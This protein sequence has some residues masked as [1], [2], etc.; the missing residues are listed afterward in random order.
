MVPMEEQGACEECTANCLVM[1]K[2]ERDPSPTVTTFVK[3]LIGDDYN[4]VLF[5]PPRFAE[6]VGYIMAGQTT[7]LE[8]STGVQW[9]VK[10]KK[11]DGL[12]GFENGWKE[13]ALDHRL[14][15]G[16]I[17]VFHF[18]MKSH[19]VVLMYG[20]SG[21]PEIRHQLIAMKE[22]NKSNAENSNPSNVKTNG[23]HHHNAH[24][25]S[26]K[27][28]KNLIVDCSPLDVTTTCH[29]YVNE[30]SSESER[31]QPVSKRSNH[32]ASSSR[33]V[34]PG[35]HKTGQ[36]SQLLIKNANHDPETS[37]LN[38]EMG[39]SE[40]LVSETPTTVKQ[41]G[42][43]NDENVED[44]CR[45]K[46]NKKNKSLVADDC[47]PLDVYPN[48][49]LY[50]HG[51]SSEFERSEPVLKRSKKNEDGDMV[52]PIGNTTNPNRDTSLS[53]PV[54][55]GSRKETGQRSEPLIRNANHDTTIS[56]LN[57][58]SSQGS[59]PLF[60]GTP[61]TVKQFDL[62]QNNN[63]NLE[64]VECRII[65]TK[66]KSDKSSDQQNRVD[67]KTWLKKE[68]EAKKKPS[69]SIVT[70][71]EGGS[72]P[73]RLKTNNVSSTLGKMLK[74]EPYIS[75]TRVP[76]VNRPFNVTESSFKPIAT[77]PMMPKKEPYTSSPKVNGNSYNEV[78]QEPEDYE[79]HLAELIKPSFSA[80]MS[81]Y[82]YLELP[83][84]VKLSD[85]ILLRNGSRHWPVKFGTNMGLK[86]LTQNWGHFAKE[87][88][89]KPGHKCEFV[90]ESESKT[91]RH[92]FS[93][94]V[95]AL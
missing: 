27:K 2:K 18:I 93:V 11:I 66:L 62:V 75:S 5:L 91:N 31:S 41:L 86:A 9:P 35:S 37:G 60:S 7:N 47:S 51:S 76:S 58:E 95:S 21:C 68:V 10:Y 70:P 90:L 77:Q 80:V 81:S 32:D 65:D 6:S 39:R 14:E 57:E 3:V 74:K 19:F 28:K 56:V 59:K 92:M 46:E 17:L 16:D 38:K 48:G 53:R 29:H 61:T 82:R 49:H 33:P 63:E 25:T 42:Q 20:K 44:E 78:K 15:Q 52:S 45:L 83:D 8:D 72:S 1:H 89:I 36:R 85:V 67:F 71:S 24:K 30:S 84:W 12:F 94:R 13:F 23:H 87:R 73:K 4:N 26:D 64:D 50:V 43:N 79:E 22:K 88:G 69:V 34:T 55:S 40:P 54:T